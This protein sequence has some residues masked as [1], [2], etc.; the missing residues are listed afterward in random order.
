MRVILASASPRRR[1]LLTAAGIDFDIIPADVD[2]R[3]HR[4]E[5]P[6]EYVSRVALEKA[7]SIVLDDERTAVVAADTAVVVDDTILGKPADE[8]QARSMLSLL[9]GRW[10]RVLTGVVVRWNEKGRERIEHRV[11]VTDVEMCELSPE[12]IAEYVATGEPMDKAGAYGIQGAA[13]A[14]VTDVSGSRSNVAGLPLTET[15]DLLARLP[16]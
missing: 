4:G 16:S 5:R 14:F 13:G 6:E 8:A 11:V 7:S 3:V 2:E 15:L 12:T 10:H 9:S 1:A